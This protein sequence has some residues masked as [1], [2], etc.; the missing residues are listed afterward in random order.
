MKVNVT[1]SQIMK[2]GK[3]VEENKMSVHLNNRRMDE[4]YIYRY[5]SVDISND[6]GISEEVNHRIIRRTKRMSR[7]ERFVEEEAYL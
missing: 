6:S 7:V 2:I 1:K 3:N 5:L 4:V